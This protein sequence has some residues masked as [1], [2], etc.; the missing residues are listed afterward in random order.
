MR[1]GNFIG[2]D[3]GGTHAR[4]GL[5]RT[6]ELSHI[7]TTR[8][9]ASGSVEEV[10]RQIYDL[11]EGLVTSEI[12]AIGFGVPSV[13]D[14]EKGIVYDVQNI[15]S[16]KEIH[17]KSLFEEK[18]AVPVQVNNDANC[19]ALGEKYFGKGQGYN[20]IM[21]LII[22]TGFGAGIIVN[23]Q[24]Y[25]GV[26]CGAGEF[27]M[28]PY[29]DSIYEHYCSGQFFELH[30]GQ[31][32]EQLFQRAVDGEKDA[33]QIFNE[34]GEHLGN[35]IKAILYAYD[36]AVIILGGSVRKSFDLFKESMWATIESFAYPES[37]K[38]LKIEVSE[39]DNVA[40][41]GAAALCYEY[42]KN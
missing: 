23:D 37:V 3:L 6:G 38:N 29:L 15:P 25:A 19:F 33:L 14:V 21:G 12:D 20:S 18:Y 17:L 32:G 1:N 8:I 40:I 7:A 2:I 24:L 10:L 27:G 41:L 16:W 4:V 42:G 13:V 39:L 34:Y 22:G 28:M 35:G 5:V 36:P 11:L 26:N 9:Q 31:T 30:K